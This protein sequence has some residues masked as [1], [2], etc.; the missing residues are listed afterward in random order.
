MTDVNFYESHELSNE[1]RCP[2]CKS[3]C[4][5]FTGDEMYGQPKPNDYTIC[6]YCASVCVFNDDMEMVEVTEE[7]FDKLSEEVK[8]ELNQGREIASLFISTEGKQA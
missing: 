7:E 1:V 2:G 3:I 6:M 5:G 4:D 8:E